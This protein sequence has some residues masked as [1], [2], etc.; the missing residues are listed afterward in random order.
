MSFEFVD[1]SSMGAFQALEL[2]KVVSHK[3]CMWIELFLLFKLSLFA[4]P[5]VGEM[6]NIINGFLID[7][8]SD[9]LINFFRSD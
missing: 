4:M 9:F 3:M 5:A 6:R 1:F 7:F 2:N 8:D